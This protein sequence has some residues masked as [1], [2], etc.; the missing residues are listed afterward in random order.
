MSDSVD[1]TTAPEQKSSWFSPLALTNQ[2]SSITASI[3]QV[4]SKVGAAAN[5]L[6]Q[7]SFQQ[8]ST[9][10]LTTATNNDRTGIFNDLGSTVLKSAQQLK[11]AVGESSFLGHFT[12]EQ[13]KFLI[14]KRT[15]QQREEASILPWMGHAD[16]DALK[17][18]ILTLSKVSDVESRA[19]QA[20]SV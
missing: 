4:T 5:T 3:F 20:T 19:R 8:E 1:P 6:V 12:K 17:Q 2:L 14:E 13:D 11:Q 16:E 7:K 15:Q 9:E 18:E 10:A